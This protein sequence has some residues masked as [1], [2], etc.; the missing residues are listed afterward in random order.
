MGCVFLLEGAVTAPARLDPAVCGF[1]VLA[2]EPLVVA[3]FHVI[4]GGLFTKPI[5]DNTLM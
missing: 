4:D 2:M 1:L 3:A 5:E